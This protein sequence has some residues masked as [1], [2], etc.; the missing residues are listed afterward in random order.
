[1][2]IVG[3]YLVDCCHKA[4][5]HTLFYFVNV[6]VIVSLLEHLCKHFHITPITGN[7]QLLT[8]STYVNSIFLNV[9]LN[10]RLFLANILN[11][12][13]VDQTL[14]ISTA[15]SQPNS[16]CIGFRSISMATSRQI[17]C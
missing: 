10:K 17:L 15:Y 11:Q 9:I 12:A 1:M 8:S 16:C 14:S 6:V 5:M 2:G 4:V 3:K 13:H 7:A